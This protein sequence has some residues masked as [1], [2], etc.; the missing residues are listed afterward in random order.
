VEKTWDKILRQDFFPSKNCEKSKLVLPLAV[1]RRGLW[2][3]PA[4]VYY[5]ALPSGGAGS[6]QNNNNPSILPCGQNGL[7]RLG[8]SKEFEFF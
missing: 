3:T 7:T 6:T 5:E 4:E 1:F 2:V 8:H